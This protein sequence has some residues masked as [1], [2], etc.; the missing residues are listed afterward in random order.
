MTFLSAKKHMS[1]I[2]SD[3]KG[4]IWSVVFQSKVEDVLSCLNRQQVFK[5]L[6]INLKRSLSFSFNLEIPPVLSVEERGLLFKS[7]LGLLLEHM[8]LL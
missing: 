8:C 1:A 4:T 5:L 3:I 6:L 2:A 7:G